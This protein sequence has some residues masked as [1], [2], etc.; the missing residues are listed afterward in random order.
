ML[1]FHMEY[2]RKEYFK[3][4]DLISRN[5]IKIYENTITY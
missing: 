2:N 4:G 1:N 3:K 5:E